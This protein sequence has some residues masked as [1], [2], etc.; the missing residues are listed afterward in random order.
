MISVSP[1]LFQHHRCLFII[2]G[3]LPSLSDLCHCCIHWRLACFEMWAGEPISGKWSD[4]HSNGRRLVSRGYLHVIL[5]RWLH[6]PRSFL[7]PYQY[8]PGPDTH[9]LLHCEVRSRVSLP[10]MRQPVY[11]LCHVESALTVLIVRDCERTKILCL[12]SNL[13]ISASTS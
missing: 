1:H 12:S 6:L 4:L 10:C 8:P 3:T 9:P 2:P 11:N 13:F 5:P 7:P